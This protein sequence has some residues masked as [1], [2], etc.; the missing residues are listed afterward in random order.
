MKTS[1]IDAATRALKPSTTAEIDN[2][3]WSRLSDD[4]VATSLAP[5]P[6][7]TPAPASTPV[8]SRSSRP[9]RPR[10]VLAGAFSLLILGVVAATVVRSPGQDQPQALSFTDTGNSVIVRVVDPAA[11][12]ARYNAEFKAMGLKVKVE[13]VPV[14]P[15]WV[16]K[17]AGYSVPDQRTTLRLLDPGEKC[18]GTLNAADPGC[19]E[20]V[21]VPKD[22][23]GWAEI[24]F[25]RAAKPGEMYQHSSSSAG[26]AGEP[27]AGMTFKNRTVAEVL[28]QLQARGLKV[29]GYNSGPGPN[30]QG[31]DSVPG[32]WYVH[33]ATPFAPGEVVFFVGET[34]DK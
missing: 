17:F 8:R 7:S 22:M 20:G 25:G 33:D 29:V 34:P 19:Q 12:P 15:A 26:A 27:M 1:D 14:S 6:A 23:K 24:Q 4:I 3:T 16:G 28:P 18:N 32:S 13:A 10:L 11:D 31:H 21:E 2:G 9:A 5:D 30:L